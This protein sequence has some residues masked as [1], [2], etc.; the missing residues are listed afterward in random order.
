MDDQVT[1]QPPVNKKKDITAGV[2]TD[3]LGMAPSPEPSPS[4]SPSPAPTPHPGQP[5]LD[6]MAKRGLYDAKGDAFQG[7]GALA[8]LNAEMT[9]QGGRAKAAPWLI[10]FI[11][12]QKGGTPVRKGVVPG[13]GSPTVIKGS[14]GTIWDPVN[15]VWK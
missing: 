9:K 3:A 11:D 1:G 12:A 4:P 14:R 8:A 15:R 10:D 13:T 5:F 7:L 6:D 2:Q